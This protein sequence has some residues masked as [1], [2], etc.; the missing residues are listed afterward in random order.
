MARVLDEYGHPYADVKVPEDL[1]EGSYSFNIERVGDVYWLQFGLQH[2]DVNDLMVVLAG[3][4]Y[5]IALV[6]GMV[7]PDVVEK[8]LEEAK[9]G[10]PES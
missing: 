8:M 2:P 6:T 5:L 7:G 3:T 10:K 4:E 1:E 9:V